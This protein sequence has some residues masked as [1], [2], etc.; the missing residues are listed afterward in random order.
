M[1]VA[2]L[3]I[4]ISRVSKEWLQGDCRR[5]RHTEKLVQV[6]IAQY[7][8]CIDLKSSCANAN[9]ICEASLDVFDGVADIITLETTVFAILSAYSIASEEGLAT[10]RTI[11]KE[12]S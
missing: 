11:R 3:Q 7:V 10:E 8:S 6:L 12:E 4:F 1:V 5:C 9:G 2:C